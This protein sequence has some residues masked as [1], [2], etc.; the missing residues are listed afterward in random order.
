MSLYRDYYYIECHYI[1]G[2]LYSA[3]L[4][5][6]FALMRLNAHALILGPYALVSAICAHESD[7]ALIWS[8][9]LAGGYKFRQMFKLHRL[10]QVEFDPL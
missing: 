8:G 6:H 9:R 3:F 10:L 1:K 2:L 5:A 4:C 7:F